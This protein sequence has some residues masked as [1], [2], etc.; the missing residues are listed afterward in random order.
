PY[1]DG[2]MCISW[3]GGDTCTMDAN[4]DIDGDSTE[5][6]VGV[7]S[8]C[9]ECGEVYDEDDLLYS[10][11]HVRYL[12]SGCVEEYYVYAATGRHTRDYVTRDDAVYVGDEWYLDDPELL[13]MLGCVLDVNDIYQPK[14]ECVFLRYAEGYARIDETVELDVP[15]VEGD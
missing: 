5:G 4:G 11:Y 8:S 13:E 2:G 9:Y 10:E 15:T 14:D 6:V 12:C 3:D 1:L 7:T